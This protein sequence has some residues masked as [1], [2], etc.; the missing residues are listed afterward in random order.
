MRRLMFAIASVAVFAFVPASALA[1]HHGRHH[2][3]HHRHHAHIRRFGDVTSPG[4]PSSPST[5]PTQAGQVTDFASDGTLTITLTD[6]TVLKGAVTS[7]TEIECVA[8]ETSSTSSS[9]RRADDGPGG[10]GGGDQG[11]SGDGGDHGDNS[12]PGD[13]DNG[14]QSSC[15]TAALTMGA[16]VAGAELKITSSGN[17]WDKVELIS[18]ST[19]S[20]SSSGDDDGGSD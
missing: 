18:S 20:S 1:Q 17:V 10:N 3:R 14:N 9:M 7:D 12:G 4:S 15:G 6:G 5:A 13:D 2:K 11:G 16:P 8:P 19:S